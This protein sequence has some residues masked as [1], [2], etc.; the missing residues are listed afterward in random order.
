[1]AY[2]NVK[3]GASQA[4]SAGGASDVTSDGEE[5]AANRA[6]ELLA[7]DDLAAAPGEVVV[8]EAGEGQFAQIVNAAGHRLFADEPASVGG[9]DFGPG[10]YDY[11]LAGL[12]ACTSMTVRMYAAR[13]GWPLDRVIVRLRHRKIHAEDC[14]DCETK[15]GKL[16]EIE[17]EIAFEGALGDEQRA[18]LLEI[19]DRCPVHRT[20]THEIKIRSTLMA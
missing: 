3:T 13:K 5:S 11:V 9:D 4:I 18:R 17:R 6:G 20:L 19:A 14:A 7:A 15:T 8:A 1:M 10:P 16:D 2:V 12:G